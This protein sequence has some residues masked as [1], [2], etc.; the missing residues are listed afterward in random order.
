MIQQGQFAQIPEKAR[1]S[2][3]ERFVPSI[4]LG[5]AA[6]SGSAGSAMWLWTVS[7]FRAEQ[8]VGLA[9]FYAAMT[10]VK[11]AAIIFLVA[12][13][14]LGSAGIVVSAVR[15]FTSNRKSSPPGT[16]FAVLGFLSLISPLLFG[17][18]LWLIFDSVEPGNGG[19]AA[20]TGTVQVF[21]IAAFVASGLS[22]LALLV[23]SFVPFSAKLGRKFSPLIFL[24][25]VELAIVVT[26]VDF[27][28]FGRASMS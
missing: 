20:W 9:A 12:A 1:V 27:F 22:I 28:L 21:S 17:I 15:M 2:M 19:I 11:L 14:I 3:L 24:I 13:A 18:A 25:I 26:A 4:S 10:Q 23:F 6:L 16:L 5:L 8:N 7:R